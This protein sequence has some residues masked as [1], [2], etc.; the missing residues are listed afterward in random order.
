M[1]M[2]TIVTKFGRY[3]QTDIEY[4]LK[5]SFWLGLSNATSSVAAFGLTVAFANLIPKET[6]GTYQYLLSIASILVIPTLSGMPTAIIRSVSRGYDGAFIQGVQSQVRWG[7]LG[8]L[9]SLVAGSYYF[10]HGN[11]LL[12]TS[13]FVATLFIPIM[14]P[15]ASYTAFL[16]GKKDFRSVSFLNGISQIVR[17]I[18]FISVLFITK[19]LLFVILTYFL[20][21]TFVRLCSFLWTIHRY[22]P[23]KIHDPTLIHYGKHLSLMNVIGTIASQADKILLWHTLGPTSVAAYS[24]AL[25]PV[26]RIQS[27]LKIT[28][29]LALPKFSTQDK[30][31][32]KRNL[33]K[34][35]GKLFV[36]TGLITIGY[37]LMAPLLYSIFLPQ[38]IHV[39]IFSQIFA[40]V[41]LF[42]PQKLL[43]VF[44]KAQ[45][46][47]KVL[48]IL[49]VVNPIVKI[50][51]L[52]ILIPLFGV[53]GAIFATI[54]P[55]AA[56]TFILVYAFRKT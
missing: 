25:S 29:L 42:F 1:V 45:A 26:L 28:E 24:V 48:Y 51:S 22:R 34:K 23:A 46:N 52:A 14:D 18:L 8:G 32:A 6:Y 10:F 11:M 5:G 15:L 20:T 53:A 38:Y 17:V 4:L 55:Y 13:L 7:L 47:K 41:L 37:I 54:I 12:S 35:L 39:V 16:T 30:D 49:S 9:G 21:S 3:L 56:N 19:N 40:V 50:I 44:L 31:L 33:P 43:G 27:L 2:K 36:I